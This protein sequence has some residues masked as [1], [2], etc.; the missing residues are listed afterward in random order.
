MTSQV[1]SLFD[2]ANRLVVTVGSG[3]IDDMGTTRSPAGVRYAIEL[4]H[5][6]G[7]DVERLLKG[8]GMGEDQVDALNFVIEQQAERVMTANLVRALGDPV[9]AGIDVGSRFTVGDLGIWA[10]ALISSA[11][12]AEA[13]S[14]AVGYVSL[15]PSVFNPQSVRSGSVAGIVL[16]D[17][18]LP[19]DVRDYYVAR[20]L[21]CLPLLLRTASLDQPDMAIE[22][23]FHGA[24]GRLLQAAL[25][26]IPVELGAA[27]HAIRFPYDSLTTPLST[28]DPITQAA[29]T[30]ECER[31]VHSQGEPSPLV[32][33]IRSQISRNPA[34]VPTFAE[35]AQELHMSQRT[36]RRQ[37]DAEGTSY[38]AIRNEIAATLATELLTVVGSSVTDVARRLGYS[39]ATAFSHAFRRWTG[40]AP[41]EYRPEARPFQLASVASVAK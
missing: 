27:H 10:Y 4:A 22:T 20:D 14:V 37:L 2:W 23:R 39:D 30:R 28:A 19:V 26:P 5:S 11:T 41:S 9:Q 38:R 7:L 12:G 24:Q 40:R 13:V 32:A 8:T 34:A 36:L 6:A 16:R 25:N 17:E 15:S 35:L 3:T 1:R 31:L 29:C 33:V 18:H 21:S